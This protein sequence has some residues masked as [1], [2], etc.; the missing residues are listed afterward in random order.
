MLRF[1]PRVHRSVLEE[2]Q[3]TESDQDSNGLPHIDDT[4]NIKKPE[5]SPFSSK[6]VMYES[7]EVKL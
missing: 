4:C 5:A 3:M 6:K 2:Q 1:N 7:E